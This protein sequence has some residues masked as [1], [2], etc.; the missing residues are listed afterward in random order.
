[1]TLALC[2]LTAAVLG[3]ASIRSVSRPP[4]GSESMPYLALRG[5]SRMRPK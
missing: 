3:V 4:H 2:N 1:M 5:A